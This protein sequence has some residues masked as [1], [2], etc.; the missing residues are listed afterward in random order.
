[1]MIYKI[2]MVQTSQKALNNIFTKSA[3]SPVKFDGLIHKVVNYLNY[4][5]FEFLYVH[6]LGPRS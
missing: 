3:T 4:V 2:S 1:M 5:R 6:D